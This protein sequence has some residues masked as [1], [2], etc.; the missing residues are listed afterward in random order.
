VE[1]DIASHYI[2]R[3]AYCRT[4]DLRRWFVKHESTLFKY[5]LS[6]LSDKD[7]RTFMLS[8]GLEYET[9]TVAECDARKKLLASCGTGSSYFKSAV[10]YNKF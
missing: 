1:K 9:A 2:L 6:I 4:E 3:L 5:R 7:Q 8:Q 10:D